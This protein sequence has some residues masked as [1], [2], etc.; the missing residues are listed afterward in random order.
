MLPIPELGVL[1]S[2]KPRSLA[3]PFPAD[4]RST[5]VLIL[6]TPVLALSHLSVI[7]PLVI[8]VPVPRYAAHSLAGGRELSAPVLALSHLLAPGLPATPVPAVPQSTGEPMQLRPLPDIAHS[9]GQ[10]PLAGH[11]LAVLSSTEGLGQPVHSPAS[12]HLA[13]PEP[14]VR[15][16]SVL[17]YAAHGLAGGREL[18]APVL[19]LSHLLAPGLPATPVPAVPQSTG[20]PVQLRPS[21]FFPH[22]VELISVADPL[23]A[24]IHA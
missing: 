23:P 8:L 13:K 1:H 14:L 11:V 15:C 5:A 19:A 22:P 4:L 20:E 16:A 18:S 12:S 6:A 10:G 17:Y 21:P 9:V 2:V 3:G 7:V 24:T